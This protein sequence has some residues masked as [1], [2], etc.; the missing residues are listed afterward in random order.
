MS[1]IVTVTAGPDRGFAAVLDAGRHTVGRLGTVRLSDPYMARIAAKIHVG[2]N[3]LRITDL[4]GSSRASRLRLAWRTRAGRT[5]NLNHPL[6]LHLGAST[7][8]LTRVQPAP[9]RAARAPHEWVRIVIAVAML[10]VIIP[11]AIMG[12]PWRW[13]M[14]AMPLM[15]LAVTTH[16]AHKRRVQPDAPGEILAAHLLGARGGSDL[17]LPAVIRK[18]VQLQAGGAWSL[19]G[20]QAAAQARWLAGWLALSCEPATLQVTS[21]WLCTRRARPDRRDNALHVVI[22]PASRAHAP[23]GNEMVITYG[24]PLPWASVL[25]AKAWHRLP[26]ASSAFTSQVARLVAQHD[27]DTLGERVEFS[28]LTPFRRADIV[29]RWQQRV[30]WAVPIGKDGRGTYLL[31]LVRC[32]PHALVAGTSGA[33][34]SEFLTTWLLS[35]AG[36]CSPRHLQ[37]VLVDFKGGAAFGP[38][39]KLPHTVALL[40]DL[41]P[42]HTTR[43]LT[44]LGA[45]LRQREALFAARGVR[46]IAEYQRA[47]PRTSLAHIVVVIDEFAALATDHP[48]VLSQLVRLAAQG[49]SLGLH[50]IAATQRPAGTIDAAMRAN[51]GLKICFRVT[52]DADSHDI[53]GS[54]DAAQLP[55]IAGRCIIASQRSATVQTA[56]CG[57]VGAVSGL[58]SEIAAAWHQVGGGARA[59]QPWADELPSCV[60]PRASAWGLADH[61]ATL[62]HRPFPLPRGP[63]AIVGGVQ[64]G[65]TWAATRAAQLLAN[66]GE[67]VVIG[68]QPLI[69]TACGWID[70]RD[71][72]L[73]RQF[74]SELDGDST[75]AVV[76]DDAHLW[77]ASLDEAFGPTWFGDAIETLLRSTRQLVISADASIATARWMHSVPNRF[78]LGG[79]DATAQAMIGVP[80]AA[81]LRAVPTGRGYECASALHVQ[82]AQVQVASQL[83]TAPRWRSLPRTCECPA[84]SFA[85]S[86]PRAEAFTPPV[87]PVIVC[88]N[89]ITAAR[90]AAQRLQAVWARTARHI[91]LVTGR[92]LSGDNAMQI[93]VCTA[94]EFAS[95]ITG[96]LAALRHSAGLLLVNPQRLPRTVGA[97]LNF[98]SWIFAPCPA[99]RNNGGAIWIGE[100]VRVLRLP[101][102]ANGVQQHC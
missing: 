20:G 24:G 25:R 78:V 89:T 28:E 45:Q 90:V 13:L 31:D 44:S 10:A 84:D 53:L 67:V 76:I 87:Q 46:D 37:L 6:T 29:A 88:A 54:N 59:P 94:M 75:L 52:T 68:K 35:L 39:T 63:I 72:H 102:A 83:R 18:E 21:P 58:V 82:L 57:P 70:A 17:Q 95:A 93:V 50:L 14:V 38:L 91:P 41:Q 19:L 92:E 23:Q 49:R 7:L 62:D 8:T 11:L 55:T 2:G 9:L 26:S 99:H 12:P 5:C 80:A 85:L 33:G 65:K 79:I 96:P 22:A 100:Q 32:G 64:S 69:G 56:W 81:Q 48:D 98:E 1:V 60:P 97:G 15:M 47:H 43:A 40:T 71:A 77:R 16:S 4:A 27:G 36:H 51:M 34:K 73:S 3:Q 74:I 42:H 86:L 101:D 61:P 66:T 30:N